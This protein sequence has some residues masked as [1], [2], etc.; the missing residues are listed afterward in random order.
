[1]HGLRRHPSRCHCKGPETQ[2]KLRQGLGNRSPLKDNHS[3]L[4][5]IQTGLTVLGNTPAVGF[6]ADA[7]NTLISAGRAGYAAY[8]G[9]DEERN[10]HLK[11][12]AW[13]ATAMIPATQSVTAVRTANKVAKAVGN[14]RNNLQAANQINKNIK[15]KT[16]IIQNQPPKTISQLSKEKGLVYPNKT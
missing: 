11:E 8:K 10:K 3:W 6:F 4:D 9:D 1:M 2:R 14:T 12:M 7:G 16:K 15:D 5:N 13:N